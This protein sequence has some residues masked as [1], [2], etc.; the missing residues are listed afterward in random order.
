MFAQ[1]QITPITGMDETQAR[2]LK[3]MPLIFGVLMWTAPAGL[4]LYY[5]LN[6]VLAIAQQWYNTRSFPPI[7]PAGAP[8]V[9]T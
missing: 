1:Q 5:T 9:A 2:M 3:L 6:T 7:V 8:D 4:S